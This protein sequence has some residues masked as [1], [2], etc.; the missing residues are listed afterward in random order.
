MNNSSNTQPLIDN[1]VIPGIILVII[2]V[3]GYLGY[4]V[5]KYI[6]LSKLDNL[7]PYKSGITYTPYKDY[8]S[9]EYSTYEKHKLQIMKDRYEL[10]KIINLKTYSY[11]IE[12]TSVQTLDLHPG[13]L[14][15]HKRV[16]LYYFEPYREDNSKSSGDNFGNFTGVFIK[17]SQGVEVNSNIAGDF[18]SERSIVENHSGIDDTDREF[19]LEVIDTLNNKS[20][21]S[22]KSAKDFIDITTKIVDLGQAIPSLIAVIRKFL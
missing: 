17:N 11:P 6:V 3:L 1:L 20:K 12:I 14:F 22:K 13:K 4:Q 15:N 21:I 8:F 7:K 10:G 16:K 19:L 9:V 18:S 2:F 5:L